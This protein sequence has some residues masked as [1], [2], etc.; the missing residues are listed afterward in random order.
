MRVTPWRDP[1]KVRVAPNS[2]RERARARAL[3]RA[4]A[5]TTHGRVAEKRMRVGLAPSDAAVF[6]RPPDRERSADSRV[7][8]R[9][10]RETK[11]CAMTTAMDEKAM[12]TPIASREPP[13]GLRRPN[14]E[15][16]AIPATT[17]GRES[18]S[19]TRTRAALTPRQSLERRTAAGTPRRTSI[20]SAA[21]EVFTE[22]QIASSA[23]SETRSAGSLDHGTRAP[24]RRSGS[25]KYANASVP[26]R[27]TQTGIGEIAPRRAL[28]APP[29]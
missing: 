9:N 14:A 18:G 16:S 24:M 4:R 8:T 29:G 10:G 5:G 2:P 19:A 6:S 12:S 17:G 3:P 11:T 1:A 23:A 27:P 21:S 26:R 25:P 28:I 20:A 15:R 22:R 13:K 7:T